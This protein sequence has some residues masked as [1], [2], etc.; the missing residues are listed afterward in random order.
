MKTYTDTDKAHAYLRAIEA[1]LRKFLT[2]SD[3]IHPTEY[4]EEV[5]IALVEAM[6]LLGVEDNTEL[7]DEIE[8]WA[9]AV[10]EHEER[11][12]AQELENF[13]PITHI[14]ATERTQK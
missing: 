13:D 3:G 2:D 1:D 11:Q 6:N 7:D 8:K 5:H 9:T 14:E 10:T 4:F 12:Y